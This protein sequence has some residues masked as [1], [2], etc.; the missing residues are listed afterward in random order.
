MKILTQIRGPSI[1]MPSV[2]LELGRYVVLKPRR[3]GTHRVLFQVPERLRPSDWSPAIPLPRQGKRRGDLTD[4][5]EVAEIQRDA[6]ALYKELQER[7]SGKPTQETGRT[8]KALVRAWQSDWGHLS[9][10]TQSNYTT[11]INAILA[12]SEAN[13]HPDPTSITTDRVK[14][15]LAL[16]ND[17]P[18]TKR[19][20]YDALRQIMQRAIEKKWRQDN[21]CE[22]IKIYVPKSMA[23]VWEQSDIDAFVTVARDMGRPSIALMI[24]LEWEIGQRLG[25]VRSFRPGAEYLPAEGMF[26]FRQ[27]KTNAYVTL[28]VSDNLRDLLNASGDGALFLFRDEVTGKAYT[29]DRLSHVFSEVRDQAERDG[30][31]KGLLMRWLRH[32]CVVQLARAGCEIPEIAAITGHSL[33]SA[34]NILEKYLPRDSQVARNAQIKRGLI[35]A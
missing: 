2:K 24:L 8:L 23:G 27:Q 35:K 29:S 19:S 34:T 15:F 11:S 14:A 13:H 4:A 30:A 3:D 25:D 9:A 32:S 22:G 31:R 20:T 6:A 10:K 26:R 21:P 16:Y 7:R 28:P 1:P 33:R 18:Q 5:R 12:W 17:K